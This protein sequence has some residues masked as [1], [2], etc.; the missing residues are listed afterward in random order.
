MPNLPDWTVSLGTPRAAVVLPLHGEQPDLDAWAHREARERLGAEAAEG[1]VDSVAAVLRGAAE[2]SRSRD[3]I[4]AYSF[5]PEPELGE[6]ARIELSALAPDAVYPVLDLAILGEW[7]ARPTPASFRP[8][9]IDHRDLPIGPC[10][11]VRHD[12]VRDDTDPARDPATDSG[13]GTVV[14]TVAYAARPPQ[15]DWAVLLHASWRAV[16]H[17]DKLYDLADRLAE[18]LRLLRDS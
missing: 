12:F 3:L 8:A 5:R 7:L 18:T 14:Q 4:T 9:E 1:A 10:V 15:L 13:E 16:A 2:D 17:R 11:R 6:L